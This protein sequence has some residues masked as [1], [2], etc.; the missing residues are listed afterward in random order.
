MCIR[1]RLVGVSDS[2]GVD[3]R[4][5]DALATGDDV[6]GRSLVGKDDVD[7]PGR[8]GGIAPED[9]GRSDSG[10]KDGA[11][12]GIVDGDWPEFQWGLLGGKYSRDQAMAVLVARLSGTNQRDC[13]EGCYGNKDKAKS[14]NEPVARGEE[15]GN[16]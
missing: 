14:H 6:D 3:G 1:D 12:F 2:L 10:G 5:L 16:C 11:F 13:G 7:I 9:C 4:D 15:S 8:A